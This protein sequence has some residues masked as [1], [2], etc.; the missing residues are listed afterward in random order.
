RTTGGCASDGAFRMT[1][2]DRCRPYAEP[3]SCANPSLAPYGHA[4]L[5][6]VAE[7]VGIGRLLA[8]SSAEPEADRPRDRLESIGEAPAAGGACS[9]L[10]EHPPEPAREYLQLDELAAAREG[11][12]LQA[13]GE[14]DRV[15][16]H[17]VVVIDVDGRR[18]TDA[19]VDRR[20]A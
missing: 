1:S 3:A 4:H 13:P 15:A 2:P 11:T 19:K 5:T 7:V 20:H 14:D 18:S 8:D 6:R 10:G 9:R 17:Q 16:V 12:A